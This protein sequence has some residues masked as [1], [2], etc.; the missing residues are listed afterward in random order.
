MSGWGSPNGHGVGSARSYV[1]R[2]A[3]AYR[4]AVTVTPSSEL[5]PVV[6]VVVGAL[7]AFLSSGLGARTEARREQARWLRERRFEA[8]WEYLTASDKWATRAGDPT[9]PGAQEPGQS[10]YDEMIVAEA[11][12]ELVGPAE[13]VK[14]MPPLRLALDALFYA[15]D[16]DGELGPRYWRQQRVFVALAQEHMVVEPRRG[17]WAVV[18]RA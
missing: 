15:P 13:V 17:W 12:V 3:G 6:A 1:R 7:I 10:F 2:S 11:A 16:P 8:Y 4:D 14:A 5:V 18:R 9:A